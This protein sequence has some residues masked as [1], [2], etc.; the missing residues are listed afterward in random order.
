MTKLEALKMVR[1][2]QSHIETFGRKANQAAQKAS[3]DL[4]WAER[5]LEFEIAFEGRP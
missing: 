4:S 2:A 5:S 1:S 3:N